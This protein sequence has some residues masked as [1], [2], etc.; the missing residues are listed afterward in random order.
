MSE[1][2]V[3]DPDSER[4]IIGM[5]Q[6]AGNHNGGMIEFGADGYLYVGTGDGGGGG[7]PSAPRRSL[8]RCSARS[9]A[10]TSISRRP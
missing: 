9:S 3:G 6:P 8:D 1:F 5:D 2:T 7:D 10:W 4:L